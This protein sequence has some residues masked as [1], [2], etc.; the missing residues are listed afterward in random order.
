MGTDLPEHPKSSAPGPGRWILLVL[1]LLAAAGAGVVSTE[2]TDATETVIG[3]FAGVLGWAFWWLVIG[4][5]VWLVRLAIRRRREFGQ[6]MLA[7]GLLAALLALV[8][9]S[10][11]GMLVLNAQEEEDRV[12]APTAEAADTEDELSAEQEAMVDYMNDYIPCAEGASEGRGLAKNFIS[13]LEDLD[14]QAAAQFASRQQDNIAELSGCMADLFP[15]GDA[16]LD[17]VAKPFADAM[18]LTAAGWA[19]YERASNRQDV[20]LLGVGDN[21][22]VRA[23]RISRRAARDLERVYHDRDSDLM[24]RYID[25]ER[26]ARA[27]QR[28]GLQ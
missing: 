19:V 23:N 6:V 16:E 28:A 13:A 27:M 4:V 9:L 22:V 24:A 21:R 18:S 2:P 15:T 12:S 14:W 20:D 3:I 8:V 5:L 7:P 25:F 17:A 10:I 26:L 11:P 1:M